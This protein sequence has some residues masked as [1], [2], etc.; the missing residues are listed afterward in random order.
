M[1]KVKITIEV[2]V[3]DDAKWVAVD[4][5]GAIV[6]SPFKPVVDSFGGVSWCTDGPIEC[7]DDVIVVNWQETLTHV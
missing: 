5:N 7:V 1:K 2:E 6:Q 3:N 4:Q